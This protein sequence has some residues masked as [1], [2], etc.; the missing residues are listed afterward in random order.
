MLAVE[1]AALLFDHR[2]EARGRGAVVRL[3]VAALS[4]MASFAFF[5]L[6]LEIFMDQWL[7]WS[8]K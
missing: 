2:V 1:I 3:G 5:G 6:R 7:L 4:S 8:P